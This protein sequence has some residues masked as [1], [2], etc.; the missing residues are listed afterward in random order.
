M[1]EHVA[2]HFKRGFHALEQSSRA[3]Q[4]LGDLKQKL[5][6][7]EARRVG[8]VKKSDELENE[9]IEA[10]AEALAAERHQEEAEKQLRTVQVERGK[11]AILLKAATRLASDAVQRLC[12]SNE[13]WRGKPKPL[14]EKSG[15]AVCLTA[16]AQW[17][18]VP[19]GHLIFCDACKDNS[20]V[21]EGEK[22][23]LCN[24]ARLGPGDHGLLK[25][26]SS[27]VELYAEDGE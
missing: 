16:E 21:F 14:T 25:I 11:D 6:E 5:S 15:C 19:C 26:H 23:P 2:K 3:A 9:L 20:A 8:L 17:A 24:Q 7:S 4:E 1:P 12:T 22:C 13:Q 27:G 18:C 10:R